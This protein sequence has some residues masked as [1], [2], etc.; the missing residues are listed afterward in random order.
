MDYSD[1]G[2]PVCGTLEAAT[3]LVVTYAD[4]SGL[5]FADRSCCCYRHVPRPAEVLPPGA[6]VIEVV[7]EDGWLVTRVRPSTRCPAEL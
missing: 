6:Q 5:Q 1:D 4:A 2:G 3:R 7:I